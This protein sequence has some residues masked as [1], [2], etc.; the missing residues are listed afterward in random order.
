[1]KIVKNEKNEAKIFGINFD[2]IEIIDY[3]KTLKKWSIMQT[4]LKKQFDKKFQSA[5]LLF[6]FCCTLL[7]LC[8]FK[9]SNLFL[10]ESEK[11]ERTFYLLSNSSNAKIVSFSDEERIKAQTLQNIKG[12]SVFFDYSYI[13]E[14]ECLQTV[15]REIEKYGARLIFKEEGAWGVNEYYYSPKLF[16]FVI[17][18]GKKVNFHVAKND[19]GITVGY[20]LIFSGY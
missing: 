9:A 3:E 13:D 17:I 10:F 11:G 14:R 5:L 6:L 20:P 15:E 12:Q 16:N 8:I 7:F 1:M 4:S 18:E 2:F 19:K